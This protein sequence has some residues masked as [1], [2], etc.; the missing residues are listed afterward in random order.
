MSDVDVS[1]DLNRA[2]RAFSR[3]ELDELP[4]DALMERID[5]KFLTSYNRIPQLLSGLEKHYNAIDAAGA[6]VAPYQTL[7]FDTDDLTFFTMHHS[8]F[9]H[10]VKVRYRHYPG[11]NTTFL[12]VKRKNNKGFTSKERI[13][14]ECVKQDLDTQA[15]SFLNQQL[16]E[17]RADD[18]KAGASIA[19]TRMGFISKDGNERFSVDFNMKATLNGAEV[20]FGRLA[21]FEV[22]QDY[23]HTTPVV[24]HLRNHGIREESVSK[25]CT[26]LSLL[27]P[28][29][30]S[31]LFKPAIR[32][33]QKIDNEA[34]YQ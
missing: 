27:K 23:I 14:T 17:T 26:A 29:L 12:E 2:I 24:T 5:R 1:E 18:L 16:S 15:K 20:S 28:D 19:Y 31:N 8:G 30:K 11:T 25:Y 33:I 9:G 6:V 3:I 10:R 34:V 4:T 22:K 32:R 21:I 7:Y 13:Q